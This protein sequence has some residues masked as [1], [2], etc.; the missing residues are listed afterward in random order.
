ML[1]IPPLVPF[2]CFLVWLLDKQPLAPLVRSLFLS[3]LNIICIVCSVYSV[4]VLSRVS[5]YLAQ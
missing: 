2:K 4:W 1:K 5:D 3:V